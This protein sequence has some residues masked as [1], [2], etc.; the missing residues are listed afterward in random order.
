MKVVAILEGDATAGGGFNQALNAIL[1]MRRLSEGRFEFEVLTDRQANIRTLGELGVVAELVRYTSFDR[2]ISSSSVYPWWQSL[3]ARLKLVGPFEKALLARRCDL[4]Y[5][6]APSAKAKALQRL[7]YIAT[8]WDLCHRDALEFPESREFFQVREHLYRALL[9]PAV[10]ILT[11]SPSLADAAAHRYGVDRGRILPMPFAP[12]AFLRHGTSTDKATVLR[13]YG[14]E[15]GYFFYPAQF[16]AHKNHVRILE[17]LALLRDR[18]ERPAAVFA[19]GDQG[20]RAYVEA[21]TDRLGLHEQV[22]FLGFVPAEDMR[23]LYEGAGAVVMPTYFGPT[24]IPPLE[25][26]AA[27]KPLIYSAQFKEQVGEAAICVNPDN[28]KELAEGMLACARE[29]TR[30]SLVRMG[31]LRLREIERERTE[32][33]SALLQRLQ[34][35]ESKRACWA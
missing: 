8:V 7:N 26:W 35:F 27:G 28:A 11:D 22:R 5:F 2:L 25:A 32:A 29:E 14:L 21:T 15:E 10:V 17:A 6:A 33:E 1:Q 13:K 3:Q 4:V 12:A 20:N 31:A 18:G 34:Q 24:N 16:W 19:G 9:T 30:A 23:G